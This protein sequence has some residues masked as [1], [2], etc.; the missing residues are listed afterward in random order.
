M[1]KNNLITVKAFRE[2]YFGK[3]SAPSSLTVRRKLQNGSIAGKIIPGV[4]R[5]AYYVDAAAW[6]RSTGDTDV[7]DFLSDIGNTQAA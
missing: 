2:K 7:D 3:G 4:Q 1:G 6:E 5:D